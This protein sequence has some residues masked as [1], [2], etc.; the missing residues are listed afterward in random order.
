MKMQLNLQ[1]RTVKAIKYKTVLSEIP[2]ALVKQLEEVKLSLAECVFHR[3]YQ[4]SEIGTFIW[5]DMKYCT[6]IYF[7]RLGSLTST[8]LDLCLGVLFK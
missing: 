1:K 7:P 6:R 5:L 2:K 4:Y 8:T 3:D